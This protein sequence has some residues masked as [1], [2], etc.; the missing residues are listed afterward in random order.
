MTDILGDEDHLED[1]DFKVAGT[2][3]GDTALQMDIKIDGYGES[4]EA[5]LAQAFEARVHILEEMN[6][7]ISAS[8]EELSAN[9]PAM[10]TLNVVP[11]KSATLSVRAARP[12][13]LSLKRRVQ[14]WISMTW[15]RTY[16][17]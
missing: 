15:Q 4:M 10:V 11:T 1:M 6:K 17:R 2:A 13:A 3:A 9:A 5:A 16:L 14:K 12:F 7:V 8:R